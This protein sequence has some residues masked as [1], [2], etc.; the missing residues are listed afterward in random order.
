MCFKAKDGSRI[1][2]SRA[3]RLL[4]GNYFIGIS[5]NKKNRLLLIDIDNEGGSISFTL[6]NAVSKEEKK[7]DIPEKQSHHEIPI[8]IGEKYTL[9]IHAE[10][11]I[12]SYRVAFKVLD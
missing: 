11:A 2:V 6:E 12:G 3:Y 4:F 1:V 10:K 5:P 7:L 8:A 9:R